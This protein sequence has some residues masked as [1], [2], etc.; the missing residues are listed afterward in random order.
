MYFVLLF[1]GDSSLSSAQ[2]KALLVPRGGG[3]GGGDDSCGCTN[4]AVGCGGA[5]GCSDGAVGSG[6]EAVDVAVIKTAGAGAPEQT[7]G[8]AATTLQVLV[9]ALSPG[10]LYDGFG[11]V[12]CSTVNSSS[13]GD[14]HPVECAS[15]V[16]A[17]PVRTLQPEVE[18]EINKGTFDGGGWILVRR[19]SSES[20]EWHPATVRSEQ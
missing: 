14:L 1:G 10:T 4:T 6:G 18:G 9:E 19:V 16:R 3:G 7:G 15:A 5:G 2:C 17:P 12:A 13:C 11:V 8:R 20:G